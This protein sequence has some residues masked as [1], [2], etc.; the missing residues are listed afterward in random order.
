MST[1][2][3]RFPDSDLRDANRLAQS[4]RDAVRDEAPDAEVE[5]ARENDEHQDFGPTLAIVL[6]GPAVVAIAKGIQSWLTRHHGV[7]LEISG[8]DGKIV[9]SNVTAA[10]A[11]EI[12]KTAGR[13]GAG[14]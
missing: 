6:A 13:P 14:G 3:I 4:L 7:T 12:I 1:F 5:Q 2:I 10:T 9:A 8:P 11:V